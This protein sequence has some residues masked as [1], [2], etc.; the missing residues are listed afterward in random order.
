MRDRELL[1]SWLA[2]SLRAGVGVWTSWGF[3][4]EAKRHFVC[5]RLGVAL[6]CVVASDRRNLQVRWEKNTLGSNAVDI[7]R[8][9]EH[10]QTDPRPRPK[11]M[12][13]PETLTVNVDIPRKG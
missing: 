3:N 11:A 2:R 4:L 9:G 7:M 10:G 13:G 12:T 5:G 1:I 6:R 8:L